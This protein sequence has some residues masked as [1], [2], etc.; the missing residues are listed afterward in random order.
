MA[1]QI[2]IKIQ[3]DTGEIHRIPLPV[4][5]PYNALRHFLEKKL[6]ANRAFSLGYTDSEGDFVNVADSTDMSE[7][8]KQLKPDATLKL[9]VT[10]HSYEILQI[11]ELKDEADTPTAP[12]TPAERQEKEAKGIRDVLAK[13]EQELCELRERIQALEPPKPVSSA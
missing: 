12:R 7:A 13:H 9:I 11:D 6:G 5:G 8:L 10:A 3:Y 2:S 4:E 1:A